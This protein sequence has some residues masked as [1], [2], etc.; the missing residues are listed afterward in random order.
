MQ[1]ESDFIIF[2]KTN[3]VSY[4]TMDDVYILSKYDPDEVKKILYL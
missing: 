2:N 3:L 1:D 4:G